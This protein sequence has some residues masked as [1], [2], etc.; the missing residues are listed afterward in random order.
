MSGVFKAIGKVFKSVVNVV[1]KIALPA[2]MIGAVV[3]TG[4]AALGLLPAVGTMIGG[5]GLSAGLTTVLT[6]AIT[7]GALGAGIG[8]LT[9]AISGKNILKG[10]TTGFIGGAIG[11]GL[12]GA[13]APGAIQ[14][15]GFFG[16]ALNAGKS[17]AVTGLES[18]HEA[19]AAAGATESFGSAASAIP[20]SVIDATPAAFSADIAGAPGSFAAA[21]DASSYGGLLSSAAS[22]AAPSYATTAFSAAPAGTGGLPPGFGGGAA[23]GFTPAPTAYSLNGGVAPAGT[24]FN[25][26][27]A[28]VPVATKAAGGGLLSSATT[29][30]LMQTVGSA[31][32]GLGQGAAASQQA[33]DAA[34]ARRFEA[35]R[36]AYNYGYQ[37]HYAT[38][39]KGNVSNDAEPTNAT[40]W[41]QYHPVDYS[42][43]SGLLQTQNGQQG[44]YAINGNQVVFVPAQAH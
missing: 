14:A 9:A 20:S 15:N 25:A 19:G 23:S 30:L 12:L 41:Y 17:A 16:G 31:I 2:L 5:L 22:D 32:S 18:L 4:G 3:L 7:Y 35:D 1:K 36:V 38:D 26:A 13:V 42:H 28:A 27:G 44:Y 24:S 43:P 10:A 34:A 40:Q 21:G 29:P 11:G 6:G 33:K 37:N 8:G 39:K